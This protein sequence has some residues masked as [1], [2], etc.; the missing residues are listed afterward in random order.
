MRFQTVCNAAPG[1][2]VKCSILDLHDIGSVHA[3]AIT[4][5]RK[6]TICNINVAL[7]FIICIFRMNA[8]FF[9]G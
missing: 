5:D 2:D 9:C 1:C 4:C 3:I 7:F 6:I 8:I